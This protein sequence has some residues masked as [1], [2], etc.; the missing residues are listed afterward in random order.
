MSA[1][2]LIPLG[3]GDAFSAEHHSCCS[4]VRFGAHALLIDC[5]HPI[6]KVMRDAGALVD[7][8]DI[9]A[10][11]LTHLHGDHASGVEGLLWFSRFALGRKATLAMHPDVSA[12]LWEHHLSASM[13]HLLREDG[14]YDTL[15]LADVADLVPL[16]TDAPVRIGPFA[17]EVKRTVHHIPTYALRIE[18]GGKRIGFSADTAH[19]PA[20]IAW[21]LEADLV[22][23]E[24]GFGHAH[25]PVEHLFALPEA[26]RAKLRLTHLADTFDRAGSRIACLAEGVPV[27]VGPAT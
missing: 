4:V 5:P 19:D 2:T 18:A 11:V 13:D 24:A 7:V 9:T 6:R 23:H 16:G 17:I 20:L 1:L 3:T 15:T 25:T 12:R 22:V 14:G 27:D 21:L 26:A 10:C 8:G